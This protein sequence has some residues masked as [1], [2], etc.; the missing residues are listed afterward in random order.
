MGVPLIL[1]IKK[2]YIAPRGVLP[3]S[4]DIWKEFIFRFLVYLLTIFTKFF[5]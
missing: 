1:T 2:M 5:I 3:L 4:F